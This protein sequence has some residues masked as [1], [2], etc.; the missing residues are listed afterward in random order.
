MGNT[1][2]VGYPWLCYQ[3]DEEFEFTQTHNVSMDKV[4]IE[5]LSEVY[6]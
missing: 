4:D 2:Q 1:P 3:L 6:V 5:H